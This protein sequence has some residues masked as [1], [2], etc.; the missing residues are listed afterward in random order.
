MIILALDMATKTGWSIYDTG[1][2]AIMES[3]IQDFTRRRG[4]CNGGMFLRFRT[5]L[6][7]IS[8]FKPEIG[9][10]AYEKA[11]FRGG[12]ATELCVG[13]QTRAQEIAAEKG[14]PV[15]PVA[16]GTLKRFA[17]GS[18]TA[19]K[20]MM[21]DLARQVIGREPIDDNEA[22]AVCIALWAADE[23]AGLHQA[24]IVHDRMGKIKR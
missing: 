19:S 9:L 15:A 23:Y 14:L 7:A 2:A 10:I 1:K 3:G 8:D 16:T 5:W 12:A 13:F 20:A 22:D 4:E 11:H 18:G 6:T 24:D 21:I 17:T